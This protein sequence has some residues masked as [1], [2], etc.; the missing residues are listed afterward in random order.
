MAKYSVEF[1]QKVARCFLKRGMASTQKVYNV[2]NTAIR[3]WVRQLEGEGFVRKKNERYSVEKKIEIIKYYRKHGQTAT[4]KEYNINH[5]VFKT[6]ERIWVEEG[7]EGLA[8]ERRGRGGP[9]KPKKDVNQDKDLLEENK[10]LRM[11]NE[12]LKKL[13]ALVREREEREKKKK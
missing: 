2:S 7:E 12:Y 11:E 13:D 9:N 1:K 3:K 4:E 6:W 8:L 10:R 5:T